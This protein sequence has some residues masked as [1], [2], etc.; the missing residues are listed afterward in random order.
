MRGDENF[1]QVH[2]LLLFSSS[3]K[4]IGPISWLLEVKNELLQIQRSL[5]TLM[6][7]HKRLDQLGFLSNLILA[8][9]FF[10]SASS[11]EKDHKTSMK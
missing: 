5:L 2:L 8:F 11:T 10:S 4:F 3:Y 9:F 6:L 7:Y 1:Q